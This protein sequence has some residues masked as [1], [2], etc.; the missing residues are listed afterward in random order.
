MDNIAKREGS[1]LGAKIRSLGKALY[2]KRSRERREV[3]KTHNEQQ[4]LEE[5]IQWRPKEDRSV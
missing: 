5:E 3:Q 1:I 4:G 2:S